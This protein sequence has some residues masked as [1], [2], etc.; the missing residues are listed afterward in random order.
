MITRLMSVLKSW[1]QNHPL[2][3]SSCSL[4][5][6]AEWPAIWKFTGRKVFLGAMSG[7]EVS[8][9]IQGVNLDGHLSLN[10]EKNKL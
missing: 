1:Y 3:G 2:F 5:A 9:E 7:Y 8:V 10:S 6:L 4:P